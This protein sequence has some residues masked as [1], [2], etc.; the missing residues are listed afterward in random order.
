MWNCPFF[1]TKCIV[2]YC[3]FPGAGFDAAQ[4]SKC[5]LAEPAL[6]TSI[7]DEGCHRPHWNNNESLPKSIHTERLHSSDNY[8][9]LGLLAGHKTFRPF[10]RLRA[11]TRRPP[12]VRRRARNPDTRALFL[13]VPCSV[14]PRLF[15]AFSA[16][17]SGTFQPVNSCLKG[18]RTT[19][20]KHRR[21]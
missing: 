20:A 9:T 4:C 15:L 21:T 10:L 6:L 1:G 11:S 5:R 13:R 2:V 16:T 7:Q 8:F 17:V 18:D 14:H 3:V 19:P 12:G